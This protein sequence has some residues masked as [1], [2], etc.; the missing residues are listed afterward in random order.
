MK[1][2]HFDHYKVQLTQERRPTDNAQRREFVEKIMEQQQVDA[3]FLD[4][5]IFSNET[6]LHF[7][8]FVSRLNCR[9][10]RSK[11]PR[12]I[13][14]KQLHPKHVVVWLGW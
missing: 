12:V 10:Y 4:K 13:V 11:N 8:G 2:L 3:V 7:D 6:H 5:I 14:K 1:D 9:I